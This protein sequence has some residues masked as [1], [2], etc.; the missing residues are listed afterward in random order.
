[1]Q[2]KLH[3]ISSTKRRGYFYQ[4]IA[5]VNPRLYSNCNELPRFAQLARVARY[6]RTSVSRNPRNV[7]LLALPL[8]SRSNT[9]SSIPF[10]P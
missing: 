7:T 4:I 6:T 3:R 9:T 1:M 5:S 2:I 8:S 10:S